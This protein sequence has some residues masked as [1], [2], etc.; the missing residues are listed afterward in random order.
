M[1]LGVIQKL[2][3]LNEAFYMRHAEAFSNTRTAPWP[4]WEHTLVP[5]DASVLDLGC[6]NGRYLSFLRSRGFEGAYQG[7][8]SCGALVERAAEVF[9][10]SDRIHWQVGRLDDVLR[11]NADYDHVAAWGV[12]HHVPSEKKREELIEQML[13]R[14]RKGG[15][16]WFSLW[17]FR[18]HLRFQKNECSPADFGFSSDDLEEG[19]ALLDWQ[20]DRDVPRYCHHFSNEEIARMCRRF[21]DASPSVHRSEGSDRFNTYVCM[22]PE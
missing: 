12:L 16:L 9:P 13:Q 15:T 14:I 4:G 20:G 21:V 22:R 19:D 3:V 10:P 7:V 11:G 18:D 1:K 17:Q 6:G 2:E 5:S 8:D